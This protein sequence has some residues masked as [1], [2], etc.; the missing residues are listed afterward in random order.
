[1]T[2]LK[3]NAMVSSVF[4]TI[5]LSLLHLLLRLNNTR[6]N[7]V[8]WSVVITKVCPP[9]MVHCQHCTHHFAQRNNCDEE[10]V[11]K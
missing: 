8:I 7:G 4:F 11:K 6:L 2:L 10:A 3:A 9:K 1:M 5:V